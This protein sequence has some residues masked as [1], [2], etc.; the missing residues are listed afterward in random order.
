MSPNHGALRVQF[1]MYWDGV[2]SWGSSFNFIEAND[3]A[4]VV[5]QYFKIT[6]AILSN[7]AVRLGLPDHFLGAGKTYDSAAGVVAFDGTWHGVQVRWSGIAPIVANVEVNDVNV[8]SVSFSPTDPCVR[9]QWQNAFFYTLAAFDPDTNYVPYVTGHDSYEM[10]DSSALATWANAGGFGLSERVCTSPDVLC[11]PTTTGTI[12]VPYSS[13]VVWGNAGFLMGQGGVPPV[14]FSLFSGSLPP[15]LTLNSATGE[16][17]GTPT[18]A[19]SFDFRPKITDAVGRFAVTTGPDAI[20]NITIAGG[21]GTLKVTKVTLPTSATLFDVQAG[22][23]LSPATFQ[24]ADTDIQTFTGVEGTYAVTETLVDGYSTIITVDNGSPHTAIV[25]GA[26]ETVTVTITNAASTVYPLRRERSFVLPFNENLQT[27]LERL[28]FLIKSGTGN[29]DDPN[30]TFTIEISRD[31]GETFSAPV[32]LSIGTAGEFA[33]RQFANR[34]GKYRI[35]TCRLRTDSPVFIG[36]LA[37]YA[38]HI[39]GSS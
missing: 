20:C 19:G 6:L 8:I 31:G 29:S 38:T 5:E 13:S 27:F 14:V 28:E 34:L 10:D 7:G 16:I 39:P 36:L 2:T 22:P 30:P 18:T 23:G 17:A 15:G 3:S 32:T 21:G 9:D 26:D 25:V 4:G 12:G 24:L 37:C 1:A 33:K 11:Q 35:G